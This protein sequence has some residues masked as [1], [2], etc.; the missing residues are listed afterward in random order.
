MFLHDK[1]PNL[2]ASQFSRTSIGLITQEILTLT[3]PNL[4][5]NFEQTEESSF[6]H[7]I[8]CQSKDG[9]PV[10]DPKMDDH[11]SI[12][13]NLAYPSS[14]YPQQGEKDQSILKEVILSC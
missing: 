11:R 5:T 14:L 10:L 12:F 8:G 13:S 6:L 3:H 7:G 4:L 9:R 1:F 2:R